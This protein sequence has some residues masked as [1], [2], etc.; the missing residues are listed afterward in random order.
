MC[1]VIEISYSLL[2]FFEICPT[3]GTISA[4]R[5]QFIRAKYERKEFTADSSGHGEDKNNVYTSNDFPSK[6]GFLVK[7]GI[8]SN[9]FLARFLIFKLY[10]LSPSYEIYLIFVVERD[11]GEELEKEMVQTPRNVALVLQK[12]KGETIIAARFDGSQR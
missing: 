5:E 2:L 6:E 10:L 8:Q 3:N 12:T 7:Q 1:S 9:C 4:L 11:C